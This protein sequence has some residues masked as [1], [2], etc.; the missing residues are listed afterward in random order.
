MFR[1][2]KSVGL[3]IQIFKDDPTIE[4]SAGYK[5]SPVSVKRAILETCGLAATKIT[6]STS[7]SI[8]V[9]QPWLTASSTWAITSDSRTLCQIQIHGSYHAE[10]KHKAPS[11]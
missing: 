4:D 2:E 6:S 10:E 3:Q 9:S 7:I 5:A 1:H 8:L 11:Q